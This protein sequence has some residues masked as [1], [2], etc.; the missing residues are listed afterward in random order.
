MR[1]DTHRTFGDPLSIPGLRFKFE[2]CRARCD[3]DAAP[4]GEPAAVPVAT[5]PRRAWATLPL[6]RLGRGDA[7][8]VSLPATAETAATA[9]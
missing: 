5:W 8:G 7:V 9:A 2:N 4:P 6:T 1:S 3:T